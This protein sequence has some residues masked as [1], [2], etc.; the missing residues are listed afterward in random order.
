MSGTSRQFPKASRFVRLS[1]SSPGVVWQAWSI[2][3]LSSEPSLGHCARPSKIW[4]WIWDSDALAHDA[5]ASAEWLAS[6]RD[7]ALPRQDIAP[8]PGVGR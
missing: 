4:K 1:S 8:A 5:T 6:L 3:F 7:G 2:A